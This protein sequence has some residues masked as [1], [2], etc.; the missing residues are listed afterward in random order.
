MY[1]VDEAEFSRWI[2]SAI[3]T[4]RSAKRDYDGGDYNWTCFKA[5]QSAEK[6]LKALLWGLGSPKAGHSLIE[7]GNTLRDMGVELPRD[8]YEALA[9]LSKFYVPTRYPDAWSEGIP[10]DYYTEGEAREAIEF[11]EKVVTWVT[12]VWRKLLKGG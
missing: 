11:A 9:R 1:T 3:L 6:A 12:A 5:H 4:L 8:I 2:R 10:E 7:L